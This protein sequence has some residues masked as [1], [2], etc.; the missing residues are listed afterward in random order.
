VAPILI[1]IPTYPVPFLCLGD[2]PPVP[3]VTAFDSCDPNPVVTF[4]SITNGT[5]PS[6]ITRCWT[7]RDACSNN[8]TECQFIVVQPRPPVVLTSPTDQ[9][10]CTGDAANF[11]VL[12]S[13][14]CPVT[15][16]WTKNGA[17]IPGANGVCYNIPIV[18][19][20]DAALYCV[21]VRGECASITNCARLT[22]LTNT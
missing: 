11:C 22:V 12:V 10:V 3:T 19:P 7:A 16:Q 13:S 4:S 20:A 15:Y 8:V 6:I 14:A 9:T 18:T 21:I 17:A 2:V 1:G 5:C